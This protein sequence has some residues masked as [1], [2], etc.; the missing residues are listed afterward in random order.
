MPSPG[1]LNLPPGDLANAPAGGVRSVSPLVSV[2]IAAYQEGLHVEDCLESLSGQTYPRL[3]VVLVDDGSTDGT[4]Q[5]AERLSGVRVLRQAHLGAAIARNLGASASGGEILVFLDA[6]MVFP[7]PFIERLVAPILEDGVTGTFTKE[8]MV[9][10]AERR[11]ARAHMVGR[12]LPLDTHFRP[13][14]P[15]RWEIFRAVRKEAFDRVGGFD[16]V[17]HGEDVTLG[18]KLGEDAVAAPG[19]LCWHYEPETLGDIFS[20]ARWLGRGERLKEG[21]RR[22]S[23]RPWRLVGSAL[24]LAR[25]HRMPSLFVYRLTWDVGKI[26]GWLTRGT[27]PSAK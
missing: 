20:S 3:E 27:R 13:G 2:V 21:G 22:M 9:A 19:T 7:P 15:D 11:W 25:E 12:G 26:Y 23:L 8:I 14:F 17:G 1:P 24:S 16:E 10:N 5:L 4:A 6:D 18:R